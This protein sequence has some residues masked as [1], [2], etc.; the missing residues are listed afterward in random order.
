MIRRILSLPVRAIQKAVAVLT[1][2]GKTP[3][4]PAPRPA[5]DWELRRARQETARRNAAM[6]ATAGEDEGHGHDHG[7]SHSH[8]HGHSHDHRPAPAPAPAGPRVLTITVD[9]T[10]NPNARKFI[11]GAKV[12][13]KGSLSFNAAAEAAG[14]PLGAALFA[15]PGVKGIFAVNDFV[16]VTRQPD[17]DWAALEAGVTA[18]LKA[19]LT[20]GPV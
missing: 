18:A 10:P 20:E 15:V 12:V 16:T 7:H 2:K 13:K 5:D 3:P 19:T 6:A 9:E 14:N 4:P 11:V 17:T 1:G 8:D